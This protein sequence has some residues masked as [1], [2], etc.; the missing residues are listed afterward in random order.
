M[1]SRLTQLRALLCVCLSL[2]AACA[3]DDEP[4]QECGV[5][6]VAAPLFGA[7]TDPFELE[8]REQ[9]AVVALT[10][11][12]E[13]TGAGLCTGVLIS[14]LRVLTARHCA[15]L[16][17]DRVSAFVGP[18]VEAAT[19]QS[20]VLGFDTHDELDI[21]V[22]ELETAVPADLA[23]PLEPI[24]GR[25]MLEVGM[26]AT[27]VGYGLTEHDRAGTRL[28]LQEPIKEIEAD[29]VIVDGGGETG[30]C[31]GDS[32]GPLL[33]R[34]ADGRH[35]IIGVLSAGSASCVDLD[36]YQ[37]LEGARALLELPDGCQSDR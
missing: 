7:S 35:R 5:S 20:S 16:L 24:S 22:A 30:A 29:A 10:V 23:T 32:G 37:R 1:S 15:N 2:G 12:V 27:L 31:L 3:G 19:F 11:S 9:N 25:E 34:D 36:L 17:P 8:A 6:A 21:A 13:D 33:M 14:P 28:F 26:L 4:G 18:S